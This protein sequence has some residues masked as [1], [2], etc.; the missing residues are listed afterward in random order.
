MLTE[1]NKQK[2]LE[3][4]YKAGVEWADYAHKADSKLKL[5][6]GMDEE[7]W[8]TKEADDY[9]ILYDVGRDFDINIFNV[10]HPLRAEAAHSLYTGCMDRWS[11][12]FGK[13]RAKP[14]SVQPVVKP[15]PVI[16]QP[17]VVS[18]VVVQ[19]TVATSVSPNRV[20]YSGTK[21]ILNRK[22]S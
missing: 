4:C 5:E 9:V 1:D 16:Q 20:F 7:F 11:E 8:N 21:I 10:K 15:E 12:I 19:P 22:N 18:P 2:F 6:D 13:G 14:V 3:A 17:A